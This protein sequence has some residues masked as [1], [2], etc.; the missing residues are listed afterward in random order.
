[1]KIVLVS[2][3]YQGGGAERSARELFLAL[4]GRGHDARMIVAHLKGGEP[5]GVAA[6][7]YRWE[8]WLR[9]FEMVGMDADWRHV[10]SRLALGRIRARDVDVVHLHN[11]HGGWMSTRAARGLCGRV[12]CV[13]TLHDE[14]APSGG[15]TYDL[16][17][18]LDARAPA[19]WY[20]PG[21]EAYRADGPGARRLRGR[22]LGRMPR[23]AAL[24]CPSAYLCEMA[25]RAPALAGIPVSHI[26]YGVTMAGLSESS[27]GR[28]ECRAGLGIGREERVI[29]LIAA[30]F[31]SP[32]KGMG[33]GLEVLDRVAARL[34]REDAAGRGGVTVLLL[35][36]N[37]SAVRVPPPL[38]V[39]DAGFV[40]DE[41][42]LA[43][44]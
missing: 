3:A 22:L 5:E 36:S 28:D 4:R 13:W 19:N 30:D 41:G 39:V 35:G 6:V 26:P 24:V 29:L 8:K 23:P 17:R 33:L 25:G 27:M 2:T 37:T 9:A 18:V 7:R 12:P 32:F 11:L 40:R 34:G 15:L 20:P 21:W 16:G 14:W 10:G 38:R 44:S 42:V 31:R 43:R 1:M